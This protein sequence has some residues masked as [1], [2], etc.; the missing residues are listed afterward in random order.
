MNDVLRRLKASLQL[1]VKLECCSSNLNGDFNNVDA[2]L[3]SVDVDK[4]RCHTINCLTALYLVETQKR[5]SDETVDDDDYELVKGKVFNASI[6]MISDNISNIFDSDEAI[7]S[8]ILSGFPFPDERIKSDER[9][10]LPQHFALALGVR[11]IISEEDI[12]II[13]S[14]DPLP[15]QRLSKREEADVYTKCDERG[16][17]ALHLVA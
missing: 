15:T 14:V 16:R 6:S 7:I 4:M 9:R 12:C 1:F 10:W 2:A 13:L 8:S 3:A 17:C 11:N 5:K